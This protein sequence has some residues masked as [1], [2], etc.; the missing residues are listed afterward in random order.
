MVKILKGGRL[1]TIE[2]TACGRA[3]NTGD[4]SLIPSP[5]VDQSR[6]E[7][8]PAPRSRGALVTVPIL[9]ADTRPLMPCHPARARLF[10]RSGRAKRRWFKG[11]FA[12]Q[13]LKQIEGAK[14]QPVAVGVDPGSKREGFTV[15]SEAQ[16]FV[17]VLADAATWVRDRVETRRNQRR[18][19][20]FRK[21]PCR[22][23]KFYRGINKKLLLPSLKARYQIKLNILK[24]LKRLYPITEIVVEDIK[25]PSIKGWKN[26]NLNFSPIEVA[27]TWFYGEAKKLGHLTL[28]LGYDTYY[29]RE[30]LGLKKSSNKKSE[31]F[32][33][34]NVDSWCLADM[35]VPGVLNNKSVFRIVP[36][37]LHRRQLH[38]LEPLALGVRKQYGGTMSLGIKR[39]TI[40]IHNRLGVGY[41]GGSSKN[42]IA[43]HDLKTGG[44]INQMCKLKDI[45][46]LT[47]NNWKTQFLPRDEPVGFLGGGL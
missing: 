5:L 20:R 25:A 46:V 8:L 37:Q 45:K 12:V 34:H 32:E 7:Q 47:Y 36:M 11:V 2:S 42:S 16:V 15:K 14:T 28:K 43:F 6:S 33:S 13:M 35:V 24:F 19:R 31:T 21:T 26:W 44:R 23:N 3:K 39:G 40:A 38:V 17:N 22:K 10:V 18:G 4:A 41:I 30:F 29:H 27:K 9:N 1:K